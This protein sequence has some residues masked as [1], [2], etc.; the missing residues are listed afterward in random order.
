MPNTRPFG[1]ITKR[2]TSLSNSQLR[3]T[4]KGDARFV[5]GCAHREVNNRNPAIDT[6]KRRE[7]SEQ[8]QHL[9][10]QGQIFEN[11]VFA[12]LERLHKVSSLRKQDDDV[13][14]ATM[15]AMERGD[16]IIIGPTLPTINHRSGRPDILIRFGEEK[17]RHGKWAY[18]PV[19]VKN[20]KP[21]E[22]NA[23][24]KWAVSP[25]DAPWLENRE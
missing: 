1:N 16:R 5:I 3:S 21:L 4:D 11:H 14:G 25:L 2:E 12:E 8:L 18:I 7:P 20:S 22:G 24:E 6:S 9:F 10:E 23:N 17:M 15:R 19:D 13:E